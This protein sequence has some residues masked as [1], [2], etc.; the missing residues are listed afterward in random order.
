MEN[1]ISSRRQLKLQLRG[2]SLSNRRKNAL[3]NGATMPV[4]FRRHD[5][6]NE[7]RPPGAA[8]QLISPYD[9][10]RRTSYEK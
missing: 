1:A 7:E 6:D 8:N 3:P 4:I 10:H 2:M 9:V 5:A